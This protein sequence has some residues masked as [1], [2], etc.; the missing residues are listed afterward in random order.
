MS[1]LIPHGE[2]QV[3]NLTASDKSAL[4]KLASRL[5][6]GDKTRRVILAGLNKSASRGVNVPD[7]HI[8]DNAKVTGNARVSGDARVIDNAQVSGDAR[9]YGDAGV[10][11]KARIGGTAAIIGGTWDGSE[12]EILKGLWKA[13]GVPG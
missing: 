8:L 9:V 10:F 1:R 2:L 13:P 12:G 4:I 3:R 11:G 5:P 7:R 6:A